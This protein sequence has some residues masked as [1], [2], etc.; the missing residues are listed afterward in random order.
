MAVAAGGC[1]GALVAVGGTVVGVSAAGCE[2]GV[3]LAPQAANAAMI[4]RA[5]ISISIL[6]VQKKPCAMLPST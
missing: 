5:T 4:A 6:L 2:T 3:A 1:V